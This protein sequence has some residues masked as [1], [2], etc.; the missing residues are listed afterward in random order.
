MTK[1]AGSG[2]RL[3]M[4]RRSFL[5]AL[6]AT[7]AAPSAVFDRSALSAPRSTLDRIGVQLYSVRDLMKQDFEGTLA[8]VGAIGYREVEFA[9]YFDH[10]P[11]QVRAALERA[12]LTA[13]ATHVGPDSIG[14]GWEA[15]LET[16][17]LMGH[18][19]V[20]V[21]WLPEERRRT[22]D[23]WR[24][25]AEQFNRAAAQ[26]KA[27]GLQFAY[28][29]HDFE[30]VPI[31]GRVPYDVLLE[32]A[33]PGL[34]QLEM[35]LFWTT[36]ASADPLAY[37]ARY[38]GRFPLVHVKDMMAKPSPDASA[39]RV[40]VDVGKGS[41]DWKRI[42]ARS[43]E[44]GIRHYFVEHDQPADPLASIRASYDYLHDLEF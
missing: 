40:M 34:V 24:R 4:D 14:A 41:I 22:L 16:M 33:D 1:R 25:I 9:G 12:G 29:N 42:F 31:G 3:G 23:D 13:P 36:F 6:A 32:G 35:D 39:D 30:F 5:G 19:Y 27:A 43:R 18:Q 44:A 38:P 28:H 8:R 21:A 15:S 17:R 26:A 37:F 20:I 7:V 10:T 11:Q 2:E